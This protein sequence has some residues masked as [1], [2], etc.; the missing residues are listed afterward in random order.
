MQGKEIAFIVVGA[1]IGYYAVSH[2]KA[3]GKPY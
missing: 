3:T 1:L 2:F